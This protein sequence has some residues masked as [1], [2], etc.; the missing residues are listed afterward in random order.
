MPPRMQEHA[1]REQDK[2]KERALSVDTL[3]KQ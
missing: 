3:R 2:L 1:E